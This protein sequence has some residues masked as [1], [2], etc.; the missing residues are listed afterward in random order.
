MQ[1]EQLRPVCRHDSHDDGL[2]LCQAPL[3]SDAGIAGGICARSAGV[4]LDVAPLAFYGHLRRGI[5]DDT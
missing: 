4:Q 1:L 5:G 2:D 3:D